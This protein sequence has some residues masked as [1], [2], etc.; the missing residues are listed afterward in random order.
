VT[1]LE[2]VLIAASDGTL[3][4]DVRPMVKISIQV[5]ASDNQGRTEAGF[6]GGGGRRAL[7]EILESPKFWKAPAWLTRLWIRRSK[8]P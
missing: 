8:P 4:A 7:K 6:A 1:A 2:T 3:A 5:M